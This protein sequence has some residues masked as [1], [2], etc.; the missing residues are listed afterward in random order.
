MNHAL[1][2]LIIDDEPDIC[3]LLDMTLSR[4]NIQCSIANNVLNAKT[5]LERKH[6]NICLTD[7]RLPDGSGLDIVRFIQQHCP[8]LPVAVITAHGNVDVAVESLKAGALALL[9]FSEVKRDAK[10]RHIR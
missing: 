10:T 2:A 7:M 4:M 1:S 9:R 6:F 8:S 3:E 5:L